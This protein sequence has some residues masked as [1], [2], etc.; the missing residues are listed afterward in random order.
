MDE[1]VAGFVS[2]FRSLGL[3]GSP[4]TPSQVTALEQHLSL[5]LPAAYRAYLLI[6]GGRPPPSLVGSDCHADYL[7]QL[8]HW[9]AELLQEC[10]DPFVLTADAVVFLM[11]QGYVFQYYLAGE[12]SDDPPVF[13]YL[14]GEPAPVEKFER[15]SEWVEAIA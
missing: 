10:G 4:W 1:A 7:Y 13:Q 14:E 12:W 3:T 5:S 15:F 2:R 11:H 8:R 6:A 9:A